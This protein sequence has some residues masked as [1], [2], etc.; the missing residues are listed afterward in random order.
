MRAPLDVRRAAVLALLLLASALLWMLHSAP[1][2]APLPDAGG[3]RLPCLSY[4]PFRTPGTSPNDKDLII[5]AQDIARD[6]AQLAG[7]TRCVRIYGMANGLDA[8]PGI[9]RGLGLRVW[10]GA[11]IGSDAQLNRIELERA[12][13][14]AREHADIVER[15]VVGSETLLRGELPPAGLAVLLA[16]ARARSPVPVAYA[17]VWEFWLRHRDTLLPQ[18]DE[19]VVHI[20]P[21][22]EDR[23]VQA[24]RAVDHVID[25]HARMQASLS[26]LPVVIGETGWP[27][28]GRMREGARPG[29]LEQTRFLRELLLRAQDLPLNVIEAYDQPWKASLEGVAGA[30][31]GV[32]R[33]DGSARYSAAGPVPDGRR[34]AALAALAGALALLLLALVRRTPGSTGGRAGVALLAGALLGQLAWLSLRELLLLAPFSAPWLAR[35]AWLLAAMAWATV[36]ALALAGTMAGVTAR[37]TLLP[38]LRVAGLVAT[39]AGA[40]W[41]LADGRYLDLAWPLLAAP[42]VPLLLQRLLLAS[43]PAP[44]QWVNA[45]ALLLAAC[46]AALAVAEGPH[47]HDALALAGLMLVL[48]GAS[49]RRRSLRSIVAERA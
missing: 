23:P 39:T 19:A 37:R 9:A 42:L 20:L 47:N 38:G 18:V 36:E 15:L 21:Y 22:W 41:L 1:L 35:S 34:S 10:L 29:T 16:D 3:L 44:R 6:L 8:V 27:A 26:P 43:E 4:A 46:A 5:P 24:E 40:L 11:W 7:V 12:L 31:W 48:A 28:A 33:S 49:V 17:D 25:T 32:F 45:L 14:L 30:A 2:R 13:A